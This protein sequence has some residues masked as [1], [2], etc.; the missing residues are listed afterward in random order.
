MRLET[1]S[2]R[3]MF[4]FHPVVGLHYETTAAQ[5][6]SFRAEVRTLLSGQ[7]TST[8][9]PCVSD[10]RFGA[11]SLDVEIFAYVFAPD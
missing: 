6:R 5:L 10:L 8:W 1:L 2:A 3:D 4:L 7:D 11:S 9:L